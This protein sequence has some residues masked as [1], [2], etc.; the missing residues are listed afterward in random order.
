[1]ALTDNLVAYWKLDEASGTRA[2]SAGN[3]YTL[4]D[5]NTVASASGKISNAADFTAANSE[6]LTVADNANLSMGN[7][8]FTIACWAQWKAE[9]SYYTILSKHSTSDNSTSE[10]LLMRRQD[11]DDLMFSIYSGSSTI[12][13]DT[14]LDLSATTWYFIVAWHDAASDTINITVNDGTVFSTATG[15]SA[16][17]DTTTQ[18]SIGSTNNSGNYHDGLVDEVGIWRRVL[19][20]GERTTLYNSGTGLSYPFG[21]GTSIL[22]QMLAHHG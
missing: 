3:G 10:Y 13:V 12:R 7:N 19:T 20:S 21:S 17:N 8:D 1:M 4:A 14:T 11:T 9:V 5:N 2:D 6:S 18:F 15:G 16:P 22:R